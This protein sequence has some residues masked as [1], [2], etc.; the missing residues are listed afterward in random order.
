MFGTVEGADCV[1]QDVKPKGKGKV[2]KR[3]ADDGGGMSQAALSLINDFAIEYAKSGRSTCPACQQK[4]PKDEIRVQK[5]VYD[6]EVGQKFGGQAL[7]YH[8]DCFAQMR[9]ELGWLASAD[10]FPGFKGLS[11]DDRASVLAT[12]P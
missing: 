9:T 7:S 1:V 3:A 5:K 11:K 12:L 2:K 4:I 8:V 10:L 6:T